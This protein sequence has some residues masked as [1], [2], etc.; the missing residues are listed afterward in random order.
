MIQI[1]QTNLTTSGNY[2]TKDITLPDYRNRMIVVVGSATG[3]SSI[4][5]DS[6]SKTFGGVAMTLLYSQYGSQGE[7]GSAWIAYLAIPDSWSGDKTLAAVGGVVRD[8]ALILV[9]VNSVDPVTAPDTLNTPNLTTLD[10]PIASVG[11]GMVIAAVGTDNPTTITSTN[12]TTINS[13]AGVLQG[14]LTPAGSSSAPNITTV[15]YNAR[16]AY[17]AVAFNP[18]P[19]YGSAIII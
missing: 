5:I 12:L 10:R 17:I 19:V 4:N 9:G 3:D 1:V 15:G 14:W 18:K 16:G 7:Y 6:R 8:H 2:S 11:R 13:N